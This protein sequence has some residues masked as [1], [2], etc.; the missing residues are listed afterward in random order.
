MVV[1]S[2]DDR[3][4]EFALLGQVKGDERDRKFVYYR[5]KA[6]RPGQDSS[7]SEGGVTPETDTLPVTML[8]TEEGDVKGVIEL[9]D[10]NEAVYDSFF[11]AVTMPEE[12]EA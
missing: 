8:P 2:V 3:P 4:K 10:S 1:E 7:T 11:D 9:S 5:V 6:S 12:A